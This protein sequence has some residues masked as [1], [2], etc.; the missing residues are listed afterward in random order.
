MRY[1]VLKRFR[2]KFTGVSHLRGSMYDTDDPG[3]AAHL[4]SRRFLGPT[5]DRLE[6]VAAPSAREVETPPSK[7]LSRMNLAEL[8]EVVAAE[9]VMLSDVDTTKRT[10]AAAIETHRMAQ[11]ASPEASEG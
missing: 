8:A 11:T 6:P 10:I 1:P 7:P 5:R 4:M 2:D 9:G 3:R